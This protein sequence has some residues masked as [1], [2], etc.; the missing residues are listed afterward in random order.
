M[1]FRFR[2]SI[3][4][5]P[6]RVNLSKSGVG[7][8]VGGKGFRA[9]KK[10]GGGYRT[11]SSIPGTGISYVKDYGGKK[12]S[13]HASSQSSPSNNMGNR[14]NKKSKKPMNPKTK[15]ILWTV[16]G[17]W[18][19]LSLIAA[20]ANPDPAEP[21]EQPETAIEESVSQEE[22]AVEA[23]PEEKPVEQKPAESKPEEKPVEQKP[24]ESKPEEK[25][26]EQKPAEAKPEEK[27]AEQPAAVVPVVTPAADSNETPKEKAANEVTYVLNTDSKKFHLPS[28][29]SAKK[30]SPENYATATDRDEIISQ[31]YEPC[32]RCNP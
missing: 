9:T 22:T 14:K 27:P 19:G 6:L 32:K 13:S 3:K 29:S 10:A 2:K 4:M 15:K 7:Y 8:S 11:T 16:L 31:G 24:D 25:P 23:K 20:I 21:T 26:V 28:C 12:S 17:V 5:G 1:G 18:F 30:I